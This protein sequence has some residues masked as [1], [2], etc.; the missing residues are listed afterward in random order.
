MV[1]I[2]FTLWIS[3][4]VLHDIF[5]VPSPVA[6]RLKDDVELSGLVRLRPPW[7]EQVFYTTHSLTMPA[8]IMELLYQG[9][10][11]GCL[12]ICG[13]LRIIAE[14]VWCS[15][16]HSASNFSDPWLRI[17]K[18]VNDTERYWIKCLN[19]FLKLHIT[20]DVLHDTGRVFPDCCET[21]EGWCRTLRSR[22]SEALVMIPTVLHHP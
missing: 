4:D 6:G 9:V 5:I 1:S 18:C 12:F 19:A 13:M 7:L 22:S 10:S 3:F 21:I 14:N 15:D 16:E 11:S 8:S 2:F 20:S 17:L